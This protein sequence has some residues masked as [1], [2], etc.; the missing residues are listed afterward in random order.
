MV[1]GGTRG[2]VGVPDGATAEQQN[3]G[4]AQQDAGTPADQINQEIAATK[5]TGWVSALLGADWKTSAG[6]GGSGGK[7]MFASLPELD[8]VI[9]AWRQEITS[10]MGDRDQILSTADVVNQPAGDPMSLMQA[11]AARESLRV[12]WKHSVEMLKYAETFLGNLEKARAQMQTTEDA[13]HTSMR[14]VYPT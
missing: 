9:G 3:R 5:V 10:I 4:G 1:N 7:F 6:G 11:D 13:A 2:V 14:R 12:M 8:A